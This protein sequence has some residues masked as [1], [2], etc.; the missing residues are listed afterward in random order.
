MRRAGDTLRVGDAQTTVSPFV[1]NRKRIW[2]T[3]SLQ[4]EG[5]G[6]LKRV[7]VD[8]CGRVDHL[9]AGGEGVGEGGV[10]GAKVSRPSL[11]LVAIHAVVRDKM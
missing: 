2:G 1:Q 10:V 4:S 6:V 9:D 7:H 8:G 3:G 5:L 11:V